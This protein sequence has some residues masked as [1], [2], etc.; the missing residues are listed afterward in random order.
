MVTGFVEVLEDGVGRAQ[1]PVLAH[2]LLRR[3][4][5]DE[6]A[7]L[8]RHHVPGHPDV[9]VERQ[10]LVL[11]GDENAPEARVDAVAEREIDDPVGPAEDTRRAWPARR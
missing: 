9:P 8:F 7:Q 6:L 4:E 3:Q 11:G 5:L 10:R 1:V 2:P